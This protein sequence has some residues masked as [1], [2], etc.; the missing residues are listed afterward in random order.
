MLLGVVAAA[1]AA[2][3]QERPLLDP[4]AEYAV[5]YEVSEWETEVIKPVTVLG[6]ATI[7]T[8]TFLT[9]Q[10]VGFS[11]KQTAYLEL[12]RVRAIVP[13][14]APSVFSLERRRRPSH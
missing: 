9:V 11:P 2:W 14:A 8:K 1:P 10:S 12:D 5:T 6:T 13:L 4:E 3:A 7:G